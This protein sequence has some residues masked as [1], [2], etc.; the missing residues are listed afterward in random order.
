MSRRHDYLREEPNSRV[1]HADALLAQAL[2]KAAACAKNTALAESTPTIGAEVEIHKCS[3]TVRDDGGV[4]CRGCGKGTVKKASHRR[5]QS[6]VPM[7]TS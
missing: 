3:F 6:A 5:K 2:V 1:V 7:K 4:E